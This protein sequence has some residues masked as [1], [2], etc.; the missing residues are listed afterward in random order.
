[1]TRF[2]YL[3][4]H[5]IWNSKGI[6]HCTCYKSFSNM[7]KRDKTQERYMSATACRNPSLFTSKVERLSFR[8]KFNSRARVF[9]SQSS[10]FDKSYC[11]IIQKSGGKVHKIKFENTRKKCLKFQKDKVRK[12]SIAGTWILIAT[13]M[14]QYLMMFPNILLLDCSKTMYRIAR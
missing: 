10:L 4:I 7:S 6:Y 11:V 14:I 8:L 12:V 9:Q 13:L 3:V 5:D 2:E 1:M